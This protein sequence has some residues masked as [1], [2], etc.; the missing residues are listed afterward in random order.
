MAYSPAFQFYPGD[1]LSDK[2]TI[3]MTA[4]ENGAY[5][6]LMWVCWDQDGLAD[7]MDELADI[8]RLSNERFEPI[9]KRRIKKCFVWDEKKNRFF[10]PRLLKEI[11]KQKEWKK[12]NSD[13][14][15]L[16]AAKRWG[17]T[18]SDD[19]EALPTHTEALPTDASLSLSLSLSSSPF[20]ISFPISDFD[21]KRLIDEA[22]RKNSNQDP[23]LV[24]IAVIQTLMNR[25]GSKDKIKSL[26]YFSPEIKDVCTKSTVGDGMV[27]A[28]LQRR[29][30]QIRKVCSEYKEA[31]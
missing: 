12:K 23:R 15:K 1:Y 18:T 22:A 30:E 16:G 25:N 6:L 4:E 28:I 27:D 3:P 24:E 2:N 7:D 29:R 31:A 11:K 13:I 17:K 21:L 5:C 26:E 9:W 19:A 14:G 8:A 10:H 20:P